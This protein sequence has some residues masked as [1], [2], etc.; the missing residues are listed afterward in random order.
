[1]KPNNGYLARQQA[2]DQAMQQ[3]VIVKEKNHE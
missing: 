1:M 3:A 2:R